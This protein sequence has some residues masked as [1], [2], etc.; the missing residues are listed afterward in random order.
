[1]TRRNKAQR[2]LKTDARMT[3]YDAKVK[4]TFAENVTK[5]KDPPRKPTAEEQKAN[6]DAPVE[7]AKVTASV[8][9]WVPL[10]RKELK[11]MNQG[12]RGKPYS[13]CD[14]M[15]FWIMS[16]QTLIKGTYR[17]V[18]GI[19]AAAIEENRLEA[20]SYSRLF[21]RTAELIG[22]IADSEEGIFV[23]K[24][25][26]NITGRRRNVGIDSS[27]FNLSDTTLWRK[28]KWGTGPKNKGWLKLHALCDTDSG[29]IIAYAITSK[30]VGD[31]PILIPLLKA[32]KAAGHRICRVYADGAYS[33]D[34]NFRYVC[35]KCGLEFV[36]SFKVN[37]APTNN[38]SQA[39]GA[40]ARLW[41]SLP[42][43][44]WVEVSGY[45]RRW[46]C[47][48]TF[49]DLKR[50]FGETINAHSIKGAVRKLLMKTE[51]FNRY[52]ALRWSILTSQLA[53]A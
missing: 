4:G 13:F 26:G 46:K 14:S 16:L 1:M 37:T 42:Y 39:R 35:D 41:C 34:E 25:S 18:A 45:G 33:S 31:S 22:K 29:E 43:A 40:A 44:E 50:I 11:V 28:D 52:K 48:C 32:A 20:P 10:F 19:A 30:S 36:T 2:N 24:A 53:T 12:K 8:K 7:Y 21:E 15:I 23:L 6:N 38:G 9:R 51:N 3:P 17:T 27:G 5:Q 47:E 49:S